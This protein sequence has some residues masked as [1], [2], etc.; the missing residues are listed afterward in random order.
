MQVIHGTADAVIPIAD[1]D[2]IAAS[3]KNVEMLMVEGADHRFSNPHHRAALVREITE[4]FS[5][6]L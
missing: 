4:F 3:A 1:A 6:T 2:D 5:K